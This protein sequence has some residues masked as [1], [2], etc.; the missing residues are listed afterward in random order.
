MRPVSFLVRYLVV[1]FVFIT[2]LKMA[3]TVLKSTGV[4]CILLLSLYYYANFSRPVTLLPLFKI[5]K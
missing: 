5:I 2:F 4:I 1:G 3:S